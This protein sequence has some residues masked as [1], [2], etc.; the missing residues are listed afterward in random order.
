MKKILLFILLYAGFAQAQGGSHDAHLWFD[1]FVR[2]AA[3]NRTTP[4]GD[5]VKVGFPTTS[6]TLWNIVATRKD[7]SR[8]YQSSPYMWGWHR[9][10]VADTD[11]VNIKIVWHMAPAMP[12][13]PGK[14]PTFANFVRVDS[15]TLNVNGPNTN[16][17]KF[18]IAASTIPIYKWIYFTIEGLSNNDG[19]PGITGKFILSHWS[20]L[21][22]NP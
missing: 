13:A 2:E 12:R 14:I 6:D 16:P 18:N 5:T 1:H 11:T 4:Q 8:V 19:V 22:K 15:T 21:P 17:V 3:N 10:A 7:T 20:E 9:W